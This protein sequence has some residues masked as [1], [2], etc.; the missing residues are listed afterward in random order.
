[1]KQIGLLFPGQGS[2][3]VGMGKALADTFPIAR[4]T[5]EEANEAL[6]FDLAQL[7]F[8][9]DLQELSRTEH[10]QPAILTA[11]VA[12]YRVYLQ[13]IGLRPACAAGHSLGEF[14]ALT[15]AGAV[16]FADAVRIVR[17]RGRFMQETAGFSQ[18]TM[19]AVKGLP[20]EKVVEACRQYSS[21][22]ELAVVSNFNSG[23]QTVISGHR[24]V[25]ARVSE[26]LQEMGGEIVPLKVSAPSHSP[27]M[28]PA[29]EKLRE[30]LLRYTYRSPRWRVLS[31][32]TARPYESIEQ[33]VEHLTAQLVRPVRWQE[34]MEYLLSQGIEWLVELGPGHVLKNLLRG[35]PVRAFAYDQPQDAEELRRLAALERT[36][37]VG[38]CLAIAVCTP[39]RNRDAAAYEEGVV[40]PYRVL[41]A[42]QAE[43]DESGQEPTAEQMRR[44][45]ECL[46]TIFRTKQVPAAE[47]RKR[48]QEI[49]TETETET[50][51]L[52]GGLL[53]AAG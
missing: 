26:C 28:E 24:T 38:K 19:T 9:G 47:Q 1:M 34:S 50:E 21:A 52:F 14:S 48:Y 8:A 6:G 45:V 7:C 18:G 33:I 37:V 42:I 10:T 35:R 5:F 53:V 3:Y 43:L 25:V 41:Q 49:V 4:Q 36:T 44:A 40:V 22:E 30:E 39:N 12:A 29:A 51:E 31:N 32:V 13:E 15:C 16:E 46:Q 20:A 2:Q 23:E 27:L 11:S 17:A